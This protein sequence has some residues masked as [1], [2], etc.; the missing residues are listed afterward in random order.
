M[1]N[2]Q[3]SSS[4]FGRNW[5]WAVPLGCLTAIALFIGSIAAI[6][7]FVFGLIARSDVYQYA[8]EQA[9]SSPSVVEA[10]GSPIEPGWYLSGTINVTGASGDADIAIPISGPKGAGTLYASAKKRAGVWNYDV[11][12][13]ALDAGGERIDLRA[14]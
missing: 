12:E 13:V 11:L 1:Q 5:M 2:P 6:V 3:P 4:W 7:V 14:P 10:L 9:R 8:L